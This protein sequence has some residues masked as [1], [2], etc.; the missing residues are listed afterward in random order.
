MSGVKPLALFGNQPFDV[1]RNAP[2][3]PRAFKGCKSFGGLLE[4]N[5]SCNIFDRKTRH[6]HAQLLG[7]GQNLLILRGMNGVQVIV[8]LAS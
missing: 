2:A 4:K 5:G 3:T 7:R 1:L 6:S 8:N